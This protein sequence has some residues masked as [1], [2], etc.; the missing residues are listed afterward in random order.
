MAIN[1]FYLLKPLDT[2][3]EDNFEPPTHKQPIET[4]QSPT[5]P[6]TNPPSETPSTSDDNVPVIVGAVVGGIAF[7]VLLI[8]L[9]C[10]C[11]ARR[12]KI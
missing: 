8:A 4:T 11:K 7:I 3:G 9:Y 2:K 5:P 12:Y 1:H 6:I 10:Y